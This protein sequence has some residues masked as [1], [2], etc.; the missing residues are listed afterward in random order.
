MISAGPDSRLRPPV[1]VALAVAGGAHVGAATITIGLAAATTGMGLTTGLG[2][3]AAAGTRIGLAIGE[4]T[5]GCAPTGFGTAP[6]AAT[7]MTPHA[8]RVPELPSGSVLW[9]SSPE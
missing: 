5:P 9:S 8:M 1:W 7:T 3:A 2:T 4:A 6:G